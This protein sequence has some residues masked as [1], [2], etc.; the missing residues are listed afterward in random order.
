LS[1]VESE[2]QSLYFFTYK[3]LNSAFFYTTICHHKIK[4]LFQR[5]MRLILHVLLI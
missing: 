1:A 3:E 2:N 4:V 5:R